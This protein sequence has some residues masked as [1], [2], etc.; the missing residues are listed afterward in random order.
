MATTNSLNNANRAGVQSETKEAEL[1]RTGHII[2]VI[3]FKEATRDLSFTLTKYE[4]TGSDP[5]P[6]GFFVYR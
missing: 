2:A 4:L 3:L 6:R 1:E 5:S